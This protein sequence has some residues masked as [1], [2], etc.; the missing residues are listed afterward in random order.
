VLFAALSLLAPPVLVTL[1]RGNSVG[2][3]VPLLVWLLYSLR[4]DKPVATVFSIALLSVIKPHFGLLA[5]L[6][7]VIGRRKEG[8]FAALVGIIL[9]LIP[10]FIFWQNSFPHTIPQ[11]LFGVLSFQDWSSVSQLFPTNLSFAHGFYLGMA[12]LLSVLQVTDGSLLAFVESSQSL[13]GFCVL[14]F[15]FLLILIFLSRITIVQAFVI[16][17]SA[18]S[19]TS[20]TTYAYYTLFA[21]PALIGISL[22][23]R[24]NE[25]KNV[26]GGIVKPQSRVTFILW[27]ASMFTMIQ[28]PIF[29]LDDGTR[30][31]TT[32]SLVG[33]IWMFAYLTTFIILLAEKLV[34][35]KLSDRGLT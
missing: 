5:L 34:P 29:G 19:L 23:G 32:N 33:L 24:E 26:K 18:I 9:N 3:L 28:F 35:S 27:L 16:A 10:Y 14:A 15:A 22:D 21:I 25:A 2:F 8:L 6:I 17:I 31:L 13:I 11:S 30:I 20:S 7:L 1:D 12:S 4:Q